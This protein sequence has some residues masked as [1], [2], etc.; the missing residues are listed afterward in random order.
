MSFIHV[1]LKE[2]LCRIDWSLFQ[3]HS[4]KQARVIIFYNE[5]YHKAT[6]VAL[7]PQRVDFSELKLHN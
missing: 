4:P 1:D 2:I 7:W 6:I 5:F 3:V